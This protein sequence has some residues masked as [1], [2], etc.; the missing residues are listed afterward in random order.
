MSLRPS[1]TQRYEA[2]LRLYIAPRLGTR[3]LRSITGPD[4]RAFL[5]GMKRDGVSDATLSAA[6]RLLRRILA[7]AVDEGR[8]GRNPAARLGIPQPER[9]EPR[10]LTAGEV[11]AIAD[12]VPPRYRALLFLLAYGGLRI[13]EAV[14]LRVKN[15]DLMRGRVQVVESATEVGGHRILGP[16]KTRRKRSLALPGFLREGL[17]GHLASHGTPTEPESLVFTASGGGP[18]LHNNFRNRVFYPAS[19]AAGIEPIPHIHD[20][21]HS[22][23]ALAIQAGAHPM[24]I[25]EMA[26]HSSITT[27][28]DVYGHLFETL[29][30]RTGEAMDAIFR[31]AAAARPGMV[32]R[33]SSEAAE[34]G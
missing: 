30:E 32:V 11:A 34:T 13:G 7:V 3:S 8:I 9:R 15:V 17:A 2:L 16:T 5:A 21:R 10:F 33:I 27:T 4:V 29:Q 14:A 20:L 19:R 25:K 12:E 28:F 1:T 26:G 23:V 31:Q 18:V 24:A 22:A 6:H